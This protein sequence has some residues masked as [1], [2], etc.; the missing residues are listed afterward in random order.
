MMLS[1]V[2]LPQPDGP[3]RVT[4]SPSSIRRLTSSHA[5]DLAVA[6]R[7]PH[8]LDVRHQ[9]LTAPSTNPCRMNRRKMMASTTTGMLAR[10]AAA[11]ICP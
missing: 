4:N 11:S 1:V 10:T 5:R 6:L 7:D 2:V 9:P 8:Q 3:S